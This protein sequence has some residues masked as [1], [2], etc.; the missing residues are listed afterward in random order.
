MRILGLAIF[1][2]LSA[3]GHS[4]RPEK[5]HFNAHHAAVSFGVKHW[6]IINVT[7][8]F[9]SFDGDILYDEDKPERSSVQVIIQAASISTRNSLRDMHLRDPHF[10]DVAKYP[11]LAFK[12]TRIRAGTEPGSLLIAGNLTMRGVT[13]PVVLDARVTGRL[14]ADETGMRRIGFEA[15]T[16][17]NRKD[18]GIA[19]NK[20]DKSGALMVGD[21]VVIAISGA[22]VKQ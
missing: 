6:G 17:V 5:Y 18:Y 21:D 16:T 10:F 11:K 1:L 9:L 14:V 13:R 15:S 8:N 12:S 19:W 3:F 7:G 2:L 20:A 4:A 22:T